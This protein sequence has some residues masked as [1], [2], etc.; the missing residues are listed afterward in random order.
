MVKEGLYM[1]MVIYMR[2]IGLMIKLK[3]EAFMSIWMEPSTLGTGKRI[4]S[5]DMELRPGPMELNMKEIMNQEKNTGSG[6][7]SGVMVLFILVSFITTIFTEKEFTHG[8]IIEN[9][10]ENGEQTRCMV[11]VHLH[12]QMVE[13]ILENMLMIRKKDMENSIGLMGDA[14]VG[15][16]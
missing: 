16:G 6:H 12:G 8:Q 14:I 1:L 3:E 4:G 2:E 15:S 7:S 9:T 10:K 13:N 11:K 5:M